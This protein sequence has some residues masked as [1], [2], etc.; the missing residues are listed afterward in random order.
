VNE[1]GIYH[2]DEITAR[3]ENREGV[4]LLQPVMRGGKRTAIQPTLSEIREHVRFSIKHLPDSLL[5]LK[6]NKDYPVKISSKISSLT[7]NNK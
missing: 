5:D 7:N 4:A 6:T 3:D 2:H 1:N